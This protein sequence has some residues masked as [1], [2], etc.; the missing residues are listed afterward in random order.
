MQTKI[1]FNYRVVKV[2]AQLYSGKRTMTSITNKEDDH[3]ESERMI[4][5]QGPKIKSGSG[6][7]S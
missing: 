6:N 2:R 7:C 3:G 5:H 1:V 4:G